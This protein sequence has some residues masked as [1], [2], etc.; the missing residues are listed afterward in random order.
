MTDQGY[1]HTL[2]ADLAHVLR[3]TT[4]GSRWRHVATTGSTNDDLKMLARSGAA[5]GTV[6][7]ADEQTGG[8]GRRGRTWNAPAGSS[9]LLSVLLRPTSMPA[10]ESAALTMLAAVACAEAIEAATPLKVTLKW[11]N[12]LLVGGRKVGGILLETELARSALVWAVIGMGININWNPADDPALAANATSLATA[13]GHPVGRAEI[14]FAVLQHLDARY[15]RLRAGGQEE[16]WTAWRG[17]LGMLGQP[18]VVEEAG[19]TTYGVAEDVTRDGAL[20]LRT[21]NG[22]TWRIT[23]GDVSVR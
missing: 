19:Q 23:A 8:R 7:S 15:A 17:R 1:F 16:L 10:D 12:D 22:R 4:I 14:L 5:E 20:V 9:L 3:N 6:L 21:E 13:L 11:P 2:P 18:V